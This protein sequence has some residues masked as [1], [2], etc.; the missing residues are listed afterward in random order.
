[1]CLV[2]NDEPDVSSSEPDRPL[3]VG[4]HHRIRLLQPENQDAV[5]NPAGSNVASP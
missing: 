3:L 2:E 1:M 5:V 4:L